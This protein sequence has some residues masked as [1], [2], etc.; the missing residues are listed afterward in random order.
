M[1]QNR[2]TNDSFSL[3]NQQEIDSLIRFLTD[4]KNTVGSDI[5]SQNSID[6]LITL[7]QTDRDHITLSTLLT[8]GNIDN[9]VLKDFRT[10]DQEPCQ[11][12]FGLNSDT[13]FAELTILNP[14]N[15]KTMSL[16]PCQLD[17]NDTE[18]WGL[19]IPPSVFIHIALGLELKFSQETYDAVCDAYA[20]NT[21]GSSDHKIPEIMLP[22]NDL[23]VECLL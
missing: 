1:K 17:Q 21:F 18:E 10:E 4:K 12:Q 20:A 8:Y 5:M 15:G 14:V 19:S 16:T 9:A 13:R 6:K 7:I 3:L 2:N 22:D 23:L 11:L